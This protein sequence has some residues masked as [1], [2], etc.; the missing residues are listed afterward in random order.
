[1]PQ[2][3]IP[4]LALLAT[5]LVLIKLQGKT[6]LVLIIQTLT[7]STALLLYGLECLSLM[8]KNRSRIRSI[9]NEL[10]TNAAISNMTGIEK[11]WYDTNLWRQDEA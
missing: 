3:L 11:H 7:L 9:R 10:F 4:S 2:L 5:I 6:I 1:M 8:W